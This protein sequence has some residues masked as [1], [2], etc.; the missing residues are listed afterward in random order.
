MQVNLKIDEGLKILEKHF[1]VFMLP[2]FPWLHKPDRK[3]S[4]A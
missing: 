4:F 1:G 3:T 2:A